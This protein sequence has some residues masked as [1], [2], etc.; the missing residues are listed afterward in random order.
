MKWPTELLKYRIETL[1]PSRWNCKFTWCHMYHMCHMCHVNRDSLTHCS[2]GSVAQLVEQR[3]SNP[4]VVGS[5]PT[6]AT[7]FFNDSVG[8]FSVGYH[9]W[10]CPEDGSYIKELVFPIFRSSFAL[11]PLLTLFRW[12]NSLKFGGISWNLIWSQVKFKI[13]QN[14]QPR[15]R[16]LRL[17]RTKFHLNGHKFWFSHSISMKFTFS[18]NSHH[19]LSNGIWFAWFHR[20]PKNFPLF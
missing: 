5:N 10:C 4:K 14:W 18:K 16:D 8:H 17:V 13:F 9:H 20:G 6:W 15:W 3:T 2:Q 1:T 11:L 19:Y 7:E 12:A